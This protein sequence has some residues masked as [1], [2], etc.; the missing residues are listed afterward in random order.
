MIVLTTALIRHSRCRC[1]QEKEKRSQRPVANLRLDWCS[2]FRKSKN[3][4]GDALSLG[5]ETGEGGRE[6]F[7]WN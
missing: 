2:R 6:K 5:E 1:S 7:K 4:Q 3:V